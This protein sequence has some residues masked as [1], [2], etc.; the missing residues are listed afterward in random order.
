[1]AGELDLLAVLRPEQ[2]GEPDWVASFLTAVRTHPDYRGELAHV[3]ELEPHAAACAEPD[4]PLVPALHALLAQLEIPRLY[5]HQVE[6]IE[7]AR[8]GRDQVVVTGTASGKTL[9]YNL[10]ILE[11]LLANPD[12]TALYLFP[13]KALAQ[14]QL[15]NLHRLAGV[16]PVIGALI[17]AGVYD[18]DT[19]QH[20]RKKMRDSANLILTNPD[21]VHQGILPY[22]TRFSRFLGALSTIVIDEIHVYR[23]IFGSQVANVLRRL[24]RLA[25]HYG[26]CPR[27]IAASATIGNAGELAAHLLGRP[28]A[29][30]DGDG[31]PRGRRTVAFW[32]PAPLDPAGLMRRSANLD[33]ARHLAA[34]VA[35]GVATIAFTKSRVSAELVY[36]YA[37]EALAGRG[38]GLAER[39]SPYRAG[40]LPRER[41]AIEA[42]L[43]SGE[44]LG[45]VSTNALELGIDV[46][47][48]DASILV[49]FPPTIASAWQQIG[50]AGRGVRES[51]ALVV[52]HEDPIDQYLVRHPHAFFSRSPECA[53]ID[54]EN[55]YILAGH[56]GC[57]AHELP[58]TAADITA[59]G[60]L[61]APVADLLVDEGRLAALEGRH[62]WSAPESPAHGINL[63]AISDDTYTIQDAADRGRVVGT[64]D[65]ISGL[66]LVYPEAIY[67]HEGESYVV[68][69][70]DLEQ[71]IALVERREVDYYTQPVLDTAL[72]VLVESSRRELWTEAGQEGR[73]EQSRRVEGASRPPAAGIAGGEGPLAA[74]GDVEVSWQTVAMKKI[75]FRTRDAIGYHPLDLP[76]LT[77]PTR[78][79]W[80][81]VGE[82]ALA[83]ASRG[84]SSYRALGGLRNL[85]VTVLPMH[86]M[87]DPLDLGGII[88]SRNF[89]RPCI[90]LFDRYPGGLGFA[91]QG[92]LHCEE[93]L[94]TAAELARDC[95][96]VD[97]CPACVGLP[98]LRPAQQ[99]DPDLWHGHPI[100]SKSVTLELLAAL[101]AHAG[102]RGAGRLG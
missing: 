46:G 8:A 10:P 29:V 27:L 68:R 71:K 51:F 84:G 70:L 65:A 77:L 66:E 78:G 33:A 39:L 53:V 30:V 80:L 23:G 19:G 100:P 16:S 54:P 89:G 41:R 90:V 99:Q 85:L 42:R 69:E 44:L 60:T 20:A 102:C 48:L 88:D 14:D 91:E 79:M 18:G 3:A 32:N 83:R 2:G 97:G 36:R 50:R 59:F 55:P 76:R 64:V 34:L 67:L 45:V 28:A 49:G 26:A 43:F 22:H 94:A 57:A 24:L 63:R 21:M 40:Y 74:F 12:A 11:T 38:R 92:Y 101:C 98:I 75:Q 62:F 52:A 82:E 47:G 13:T 86:A 17:R 72:R 95:P 6:T 87:C 58:L 37:H 81:W 73:V 7:H 93:L 35:R 5:A 1:M 56:L 96:C 31:S 15:R 4:P 61:A 9:A 25:A